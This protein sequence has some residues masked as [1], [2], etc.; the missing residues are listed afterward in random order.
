MFFPCNVRWIPKTSPSGYFMYSLSHPT[1]LPTWCSRTHN[2]SWHL[3]PL[4]LQHTS[5]HRF[6]H[7]ESDHPDHGSTK[8][9]RWGR[10]QGLVPQPETFIRRPPYEFCSFGGSRYMMMMM[11]MMMM[12]WCV[13][14]YMCICVYVYMC[15]CVYVYTCM[16]I[17]IC[18][19]VYVYMC[20]CVYVYMCICVCIRA[21]VA[22]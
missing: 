12:M 1:F 10:C 13:Y 11:M 16:C 22:E 4:H 9:G 7:T 20:I 6:R 8:L 18:I 14:V 5:I 2:R 19:S 21:S 3:A 17:Y 15:T